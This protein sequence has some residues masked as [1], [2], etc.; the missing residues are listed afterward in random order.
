MPEAPIVH[1]EHDWV[2]AAYLPLDNRQAKHA[3]R[4]GSVRMKSDAKVEVL[5]V[6]CKRCRRPHPE[7][8][9]QPCIQTQCLHG[10]PVGERKKRGE[11]D[12][13][14]APASAASA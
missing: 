4:R 7:V 11:D 1:D 5:E 2:G 10:G 6:M 3:E 8:V 14:E 12:A 9:D 13:D